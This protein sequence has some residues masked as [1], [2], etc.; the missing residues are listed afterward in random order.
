MKKVKYQKL[1]GNFFEVE[2][3]ENLPCIICGLPVVA[4]SMGGT[5]ICPWCDCGK[6][7]NGQQFTIVEEMN[8]EILRENAQKIQNEK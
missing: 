4:A 7:R 5:N 1:D 2:Y 3:D 8:H 6:H